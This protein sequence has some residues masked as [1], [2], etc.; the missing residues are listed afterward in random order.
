[1][2]ELIPWISPLLAAWAVTAS[3]IGVNRADA[4]RARA[5]PEADPDEIFELGRSAF[6]AEPIDIAAA[7]QAVFQDVA[8]DAARHRSRIRVAVA[9]DLLVCADRRALR[10]GLAEL[11]R[12]SLRLSP[13]AAVL[14]TARRHGGRIEVSCL[15]DGPPE[16]GMDLRGALRDAVTVFALHGATME[17]DPR[18]DGAVMRVRLP[19]YAE[20][21]PTPTAAA[22][23]LRPARLTAD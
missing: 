4:W 5:R 2:A 6:A 9:P 3:A 20:R 22:P 12:M 16:I 14:V 7:L 17:V 19:E 18:L 1:M 10:H 13:C 8:R 21:A 15:A 23:A 11:V